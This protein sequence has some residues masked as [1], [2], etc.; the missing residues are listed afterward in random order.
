MARSI[1]RSNPASRKN[2]SI[3]WYDFA[4]ELWGKDYDPDGWED[5]ISDAAW[6]EL[7]SFKKR[8]EEDL[9]REMTEE[10]ELSAQAALTDSIQERL[11]SRNLLGK[12]NAV[13]RIVD[14]INDW[15]A[16]GPQLTSWDSE[17]KLPKGK[18]I[19]GVDETAKGVTFTLARPFLTAYAEAAY[20]A[21]G[22]GDEGLELS[23]MKGHNVVSVAKWIIDA[24]GDRKIGIPDVQIESNLTYRK[25]MDIVV[26]PRRK[27]SRRK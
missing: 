5:S 26:P 20:A 10:E 12:A 6:E 7:Q 3:T 25:L 21:L 15:G 16:R 17:R 24:Q 13:D 19:L 9:D 22:F 18:A 14:L 8:F 1:R 11:G 2:V 23:D 4:S 27:R